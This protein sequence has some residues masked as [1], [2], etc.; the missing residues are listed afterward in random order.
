VNGEEEIDK[1][2]DGRGEET[3]ASEDRESSVGLSVCFDDL[4]ISQNC[5]ISNPNNLYKYEQKKGKVL[6]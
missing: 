1:I 4:K 3:R 2:N 5:E 6:R